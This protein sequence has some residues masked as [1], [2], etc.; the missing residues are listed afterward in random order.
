[1]SSKQKSLL[2]DR[3]ATSIQSE[4]SEPMEPELGAGTRVEARI[5]NCEPK[6]PESQQ[7]N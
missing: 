2:A 5:V 3:I 1:M 7:E 4:P 6:Q